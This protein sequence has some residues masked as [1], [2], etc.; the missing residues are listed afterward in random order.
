MLKKIIM[1]SVTA[2]A[3]LSSAPAYAESVFVFRHRGAGMIDAQR[4]FV[5]MRIDPRLGACRTAVRRL[6][7]ASGS[8][9]DGAGDVNGFRQVAGTWQK[10]EN[11]A[12]VCFDYNPGTRTCRD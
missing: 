8:P 3:I 2:A 10:L 9:L 12:V 5:C 1:S 11:G 6:L 7:T 4:E